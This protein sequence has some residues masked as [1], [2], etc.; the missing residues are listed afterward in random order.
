[1][2]IWEQKE[3]TYNHNEDIRINRLLS[4][5]TMS[6]KIILFDDNKALQNL[7]TYFYSN[8]DND[9]IDTVKSMDCP[10]QIEKYFTQCKAL[11]GIKEIPRYPIPTNINVVIDM[12]DKI[13][14]DRAIEMMNNK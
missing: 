2:S 8:V 5:K 7:G 4:K 14:V 3:Q 13:D 6:A 12:R 9:F 10:Y 1:M 11:K